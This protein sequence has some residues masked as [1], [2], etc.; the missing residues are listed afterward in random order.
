MKTARQLIPVGE[1]IYWSIEHGRAGEVIVELQ[2][3]QLDAMRE[4][5]MKAAKICEGRITESDLTIEATRCMQK[6]LTAAEQLTEKDLQ[7]S[8]LKAAAQALL[9]HYVSL[10]RSGDAGTWDPETEEPVI[11]L[12]KAL[13]HDPRT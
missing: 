6:I 4:G 5:M 10:A 1:R 7:P 13:S 12:R 8:E 2:A 9:D 11:R 3:V